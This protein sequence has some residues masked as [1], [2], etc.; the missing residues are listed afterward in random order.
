MPLAAL[1]VAQDQVES[2]EGLRAVLPVAGRTLIEHQAGLLRG[3]GVDHLV[4]LVERVPA[5][6]AQAV[7]RMRR[8]GARIDVARTIGDAIDRIHPDERIMLVADGAVA[9][10]GAVDALA[11]A[12]APAVLAV[13]DT[14][15]NEDFERIDAAQRW[16]GFALLSRST[17]EATAN[18]LGDWDLSSTVLR[19][20]VQNDAERIAALDPTGTDALS[21]PVIATGARSVLAIEA[22]LLR[23][24]ETDEGNW[25]ERHLHRLIARPLL[26][27]LVSRQV[28]D[29]HVAWAAVGIA[30]LAALAGAFDFF[31][32]A[33]ILLPLSAAAASAAMRIT[34]IWGGAATQR[35]TLAARHA[36]GFILLMLL[37]KH[38]AAE[39]GWGWWTVA[40]LIPVSLAGMAALDPVAHA[41]RQEPSPRWLASAD[42][43]AWLAPLFAVVGGWRWMLAALATYV[44]AS[45]A[46]RLHSAWKEARTMTAEA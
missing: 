34:R 45:F 9:A 6:L 20:L 10:Q 39:T 1:I 23:R 32:V 30:W 2:G 21:P 4:L 11:D 18:M 3:A 24:A 40:G 12:A 28:D 13:P 27:Q 19:R 17:L 42:A 31:W 46:D 14:Q 7:D 22:G 38:L 35:L 44:A 41:L 5:S 8:D 37:A 15:D 16:A 33:A 26:P 36:A 25:V 43:L 29:M